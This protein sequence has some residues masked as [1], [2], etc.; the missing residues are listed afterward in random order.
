MGGSSDDTA[1]LD[2]GTSAAGLCAGSPGGPPRRN[3]VNGTGNGAAGS[4]LRESETGL[5]AE[6]SSNIDTALARLGASATGLGASTESTP[7]GDDAVNG[8]SV[9][10]AV[11]FVGEG[12]AGL[13]TVG[14]GGGHDPESVLGAGATAHRADS[15]GR[16]GRN[17]TVNRAG[18]G[19]ALAAFLEV[20]AHVAPVVGVSDNASGAEL[21]ALTAGL[22][23]GRPGGPVRDKAVHGAV[24]VA[25]HLLVEKI[26]AD[27]TTMGSSGDDAPGASVGANATG[28][29]TDAPVVEVGDDTVNRA[30][31]GV[32][33]TRLGKGR[34]Q[35]AAEGNVA[36]DGACARLGPSAAGLGAGGP[37]IP[38]GHNAVDGAV[39]GVASSL[40]G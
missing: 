2:L 19:A 30:H 20:R 10:V 35:L 32:A 9:G 14:D 23:A 31:L 8:A 34:T 36:G 17:D 24:A 3:T 4:C 18:L 37:V 25:A 13:A 11:R 1:S 40:L 26:G 27:H 12:G 15:P 38:G 28:L 21:L 7:G 16:P 22:G 6:R 39:E 5:S 33:L 29:G